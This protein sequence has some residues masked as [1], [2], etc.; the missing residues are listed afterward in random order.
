MNVKINNK[1]YPVKALGFKDMIHMEDMGFPIFSL[2]KDKKVF[3]MAVA[4]VG[5]VAECDRDEAERLCEQHL[6][7]GGNLGDLVATFDKALDESDFFKKLLGDTQEK[8]EKPKANAK[9]E[10]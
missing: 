8:T 6:L 7:G 3:S 10:K 9:V 5:I 1:N 2:I 4:F